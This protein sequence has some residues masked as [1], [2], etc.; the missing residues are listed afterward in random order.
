MELKISQSINTPDEMT[1]QEIKR[2]SCALKSTFE[3]CTCLES[4]MFVL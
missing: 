2:S 1:L 4:L 3:L